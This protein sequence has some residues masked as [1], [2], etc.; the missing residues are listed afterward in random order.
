MRRASIIGAGFAA[1]LAS[2]AAMPAFAAFGAFALDEVA[3]KYGYS[4]NQPTQKSA[5]QQAVKNCKSS[6]C[7]VVFPIG[8]RQCGALATTADG[9]AW[10]GAVR[11]KRE[12]A[13]QAALQDCQKR[14][15]GQ[16]KVQKGVCNR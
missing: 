1:V 8:P 9:S 12:D 11:P 4:S 5:D 3:H 16:C 10:G 13:Q 15:S 6:N 2:A 7:K 14:T